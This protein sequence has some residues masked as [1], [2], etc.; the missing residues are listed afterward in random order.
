[1]DLKE[2]IH[3]ADGVKSALIRGASDLGEGRP[4][5]LGAAGPRE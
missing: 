2:V 3:H 5:L 1:L 4:D